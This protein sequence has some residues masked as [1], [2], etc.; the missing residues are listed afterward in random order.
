M[1]MF[2]LLRDRICETLSVQITDI[3]L[4]V[5]ISDA[6]PSYLGVADPSN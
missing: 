6:P 1:G 4:G 3:E 2:N 5:K